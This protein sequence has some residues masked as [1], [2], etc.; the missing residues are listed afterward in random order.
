M[1][2][3]KVL[4]TLLAFG[5]MIFSCSKEG[6]KSERFKLLTGHIWV[7]DSLLAGGIDASGLGGLLHNF[8][9]DTKFNEDGTG[10]VGGIEGTWHFFRNETQIVITTDSL[11]LPVTS[12]IVELTSNSLKIT[13]SYPIPPAV[14]DIRMTFIP[15]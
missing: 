3:Y 7:S 14:V 1:K 13:T 8:R 11:S 12:N 4:F 2:K 6:P 15:K 5:F 9:G 10:Y